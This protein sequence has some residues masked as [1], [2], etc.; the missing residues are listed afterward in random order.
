MKIKLFIFCLILI[1]FLSG[2]Y[3]WHINQNDLHLK[4]ITFNQLPG[5]KNANTLKSLQAFNISCKTFLKKQPDA[6]VGSP[7]IP[8]TA[9]SWH[10]P[11]RAALLIDSTSNKQ[12]KAF[13][14]QWFVPV[15]F[16]Y[17]NPVQGL[18]TGYYLPLVH[19]SLT[20]TDHYHTPIYRT[21]DD[22][23]TINLGLFDPAL[24][25]RQFFGR[26]KGGTILPY[27]TREEINQG[28]ISKSASVL[29]WVNSPIDRLF[30]EIEGSGFIE[31]TDGSRMALGYASQNGASYTAVGRVLIQQGVM[32][33]DKMSMQGIRHYLESHPDQIDSVINQNKSFVFF[34]KLSDDL[35][36][37]VQ[38]I[39]LTPGYSL[40]VD[41]RWVPI[42][43]PIWL[44]TTR[45]AYQKNQQKKLQ[46]L[47]I[48]QD[49]GGAIRGMVRGDVFW[50]AGDKAAD[51]AGKMNNTGYY[52]VLLPKHSAHLL[53]K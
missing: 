1:S 20:K 44:N 27:Y 18:F 21:P 17:H 12:A 28:A 30:L 45:P 31:L 16:F 26:L 29:A 23:I 33:K 48:A 43:V 11:C 37:G 36:V 3:L 47:M 46:R 49:T 22:M 39:P 50:G 13:F 40:A 19:G 41:R 4:T 15:E 9:K 2:G 51:I 42:G 32:T 14:E 35:A 10:P 38:E 7:Y 5:W 34:E 53:D 8:L 25:N 24:A 6:P 52:W